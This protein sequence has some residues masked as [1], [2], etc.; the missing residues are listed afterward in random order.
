MIKLYD[1]SHIYWQDTYHSHLNPTHTVADNKVIS[2]SEL[3]C[4]NTYP[5]PKCE[6]KTYWDFET[7]I[8]PKLF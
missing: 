8:H 1:K 3:N 7:L 5:L 2:N 4:L 6:G